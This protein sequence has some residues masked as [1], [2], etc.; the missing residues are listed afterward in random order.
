M[1]FKISIV[2]INMM[3]NHKIIK[4]KLVV[5]V[6]SPIVIKRNGTI[7]EKWPNEK[8][9]VTKIEL[10][11][12]ALIFFLVNILSIKKSMVV[13]RRDTINGYKI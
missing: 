9:S 13:N 5:I 3:S 2:V 12:A 10:I 4:P 11:T 8:K 7:F 6:N 1:V